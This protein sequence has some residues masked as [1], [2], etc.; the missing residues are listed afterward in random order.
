MLVKVRLQSP[1]FLLQNLLQMFVRK[2]NFSAAL[3]Q[4]RYLGLVT[5]LTSLNQLVELAYLN[6]FAL[7]LVTLEMVF[8]KFQICE[9]LIH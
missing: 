7:V 5:S 2:I 1:I 3:F 4:M 6:K 8:M 9:S